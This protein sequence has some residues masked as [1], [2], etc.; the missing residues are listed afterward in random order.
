MNVHS[1]SGKSKQILSNHGLQFMTVP[2]KMSQ[3]SSTFTINRNE[4]E[5]LIIFHQHLTLNSYNTLFPWHDVTSP[6]KLATIINTFL[7][8][9]ISNLKS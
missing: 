5:F 9:Q 6:I 7:I 1:R 2:S 8:F 4:K 3:N